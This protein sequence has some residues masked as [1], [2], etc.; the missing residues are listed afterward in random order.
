[1]RAIT[2]AHNILKDDDARALYN[3][4]CSLQKGLEA[5]VDIFANAPSDNG[6]VLV[7]FTPDKKPQPVSPVDAAAD[8]ARQVC[9]FRLGISP[10]WPEHVLSMLSVGFP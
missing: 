1:M 10:F 4:R 2:D 6:R 8:A 3:V 7:L 5:Y 9:T